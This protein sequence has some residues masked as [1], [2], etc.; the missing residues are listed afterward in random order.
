MLNSYLIV[1]E[2]LKP[3][4]IRGELKVKPITSDPDRFYDLKEVYFKKGE[5][6]EKRSVHCK[7]VHDGFAYL[8]MQSVGDRDEAEK[9]RGQL[10]YIQRKDAIALQPEEDFIC[11]LVGCVALDTKGNKVGVLREIM[12][13]GANDVYIIDTPRG[14]LLLPALK[15]VVIKTD[16]SSRTITLDENEIDTFAVWSDED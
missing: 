7:R 5:T 2:I 13:P 12:Q 14:E 9:L 4:G 15:R 10:L 16:V 8:T 3:Q 1:G 11:D 6:Y